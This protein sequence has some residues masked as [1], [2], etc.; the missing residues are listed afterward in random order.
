MKTR[1][2]WLTKDLAGYCQICGEPIYNM[3]YSTNPL[4]TTV[5]WECEHQNAVRLVKGI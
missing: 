1:P 5:K 3:Y 4:M 2:R